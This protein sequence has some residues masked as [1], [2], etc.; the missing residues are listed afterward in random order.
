MI[1]HHTV[2]D[3]LGAA[4]SPCPAFK[5]VCQSMRW[6]PTVG[7]VPRGFAG[8]LRGPQQVRLVLVTAEP[9]DPYDSESYPRH[10]SPRKILE[11]ACRHVY[12]A[13]QNGPDRYHQNL[14]H[15][16]NRCFPSLSFEEQMSRTWLTDS[17]LCSAH[18]EG[19]R[20]RM[21]IAH[22]CRH[23]YLDAQLALFP[24]AL[25]VA[26][27]GKAAYRLR[28][29]PGVLSA[30]SVAAPGCHRAKARPSWDAVVA[31]FR[32]R[33]RRAERRA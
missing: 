21:P 11:T 23:R 13:L 8:A 28:G 7:H 1:P 33:A 30:F 19:G 26:L 18:V 31:A 12:E 9:G 3:T 6:A 27:G 15:I 24:R 5:T 16:L 2:L 22:E 25:V 14:R 17:V 29:V 4:Y 32:A 10:A 20:I